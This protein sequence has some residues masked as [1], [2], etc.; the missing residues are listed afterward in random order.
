MTTSFGNVCTHGHLVVECSRLVPVVRRPGA[1]Y[2]EPRAMYEGE[3]QALQRAG[4]A[5]ERTLH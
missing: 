3:A 5:A 4:R 2:E 1:R